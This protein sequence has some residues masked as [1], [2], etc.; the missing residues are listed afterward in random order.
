MLTFTISNAD[1]LPYN[2][3]VPN[4]A[5]DSVLRNYMVDL[6]EPDDLALLQDLHR[7]VLVCFL[8]PGELHPTEG[9]LWGKGGVRARANLFQVFGT[10]HNP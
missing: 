6:L 5:E 2:A 8:V 4:I 1:K 3:R 10:S 9:A 7:V